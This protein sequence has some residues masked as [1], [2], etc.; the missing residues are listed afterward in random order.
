MRSPTDESRFLVFLRGAFFLLIVPLLSCTLGTPKQAA[1]PPPPKPA[2]VAPPA[3]E[4]PL[5]VPQ[6]AVVLPS[7]Q[8][9]NPDAIPTVQVA[10][11]PVP[12]K[13]DPPA[14]PHVSRRAASPPKPDPETEPG[15]PPAPAPAVE[16]QP[17]QPI[18]TGEEQKRLEGLIDTRK[19]ATLEKLGRAQGRLSKHDQTLVERIKTFMSQCEE[20]L[21]RGDFSQADALSERALILAQELQIE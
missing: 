5:S 9:V 2:A 18:L 17:I 8:Y 7:P 10:Q 12:E 19:R 6:T 21:K 15:T 20:A 13:A 4:A 14:T 1:A 11:A 16:E 3:P